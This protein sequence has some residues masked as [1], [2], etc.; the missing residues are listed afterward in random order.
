MKAVAIDAGKG[1]VVPLLENVVKGTYSPL[2]RPL[3]LYVNARAAERLEIRQFIAFYL[4]NAG[5]IAAHVKYVPLPDRAYTV[6]R[7]RFASGRLGTAFGGEAAISL[8]VD[9]I[10]SREP[11]L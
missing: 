3:F 9:D 7:D 4:Q 5:K 10:V 11:R 8:Q 2:S 1:P 6:V